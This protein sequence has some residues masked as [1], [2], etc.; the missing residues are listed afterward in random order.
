MRMNDLS[1][2]KIYFIAE[3]DTVLSK[4]SVN[5]YQTP[6]KLCNQ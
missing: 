5:S 3:N 6:G 2:K 1:L 4:V